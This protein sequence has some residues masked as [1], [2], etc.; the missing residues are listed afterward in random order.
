MT[1]REEALRS[2]A[3]PTSSL[4]PPPGSAAA[5]VLE[6]IESAAIAE[7]MGVQGYYASAFSWHSQLVSSKAKPSA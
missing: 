6:H 3:A 2:D 1:F 7:A 5:D 4:A